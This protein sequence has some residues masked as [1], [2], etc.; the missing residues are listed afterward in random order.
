MVRSTF[1][2]LQSKVSHSRSLVNKSP[3]TSGVRPFQDPKARASA[4]HECVAKLERALSAMDVMQ[5]PVV[6][7]LRVALRRA[8][9]ATH[10]LPS[11]SR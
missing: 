6:D 11:T 7:S 5:G 8:R 4:V 2:S 10:S 3:K 9:E 1:V